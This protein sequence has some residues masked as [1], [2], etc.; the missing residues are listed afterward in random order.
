VRCLI[1]TGYDDDEAINA[2]VLAGAA[3]Y[4]IKDVRGSGLLDSL[5]K[6]AAGRSLIDPS[7]SRRVVER[8]HERHQADPRLASLSARERDI[9]PLIAEGLTNR[10]IGVRLTLA[11]KT[12]KNYISGLLSKLGLQRRTQAAILHLESQAPPT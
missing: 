5:R 1:L 2:A 9:L 10:E 7:L 8:I 3:G 4:V 12:V 11:E 6:V